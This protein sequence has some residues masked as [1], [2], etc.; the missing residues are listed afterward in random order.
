MQNISAGVST[1]RGCRA[2]LRMALHEVDLRLPSYFWLYSE[3][4]H[5][6]LA[7][8]WNF[9][10]GHTTHRRWRRSHYW[11]GSS[12]S[13]WWKLKP[14]D[15]FFG[16][17]IRPD[18]RNH[19]LKRCL[20]HRTDLLRQSFHRESTVK[21]PILFRQAKRLSHCSLMKPRSSRFRFRFTLR[22]NFRRWH[23]MHGSVFLRD[24]LPAS[25]KQYH[26]SVGCNHP[27]VKLFT[28]LPDVSIW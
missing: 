23:K 12:K 20:I 11:T 4:R 1:N 16:V 5:V 21:R 14:K 25:N 7:A 22:Q 3:T 2:I 13:A 9:K 28:G 26:S 6:V 15:T 18:G 27:T 8:W 19:T 24:D 10:F 17:K